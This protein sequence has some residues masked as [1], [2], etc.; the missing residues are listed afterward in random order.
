MPGGK[1]VVLA[2]SAAVAVLAVPVLAQTGG[3]IPEEQIQ[4]GA[5]IYSQNCAPCHGP[6][7]LDSQ[8]PL[9]LRKFPP[10][11]KARFVTS[12]VKGKDQMPPYGNLFN[13][14]E[15]EA[16]WAYVIAGEKP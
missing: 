2:V 7:M 11:E 10:G 1:A 3:P 12:V 6:P 9:G 5:G 13:A 8:G 15:I 4:K 16:L 14:E